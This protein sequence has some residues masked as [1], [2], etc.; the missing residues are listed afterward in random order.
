MKIPT[1][2]L[3]Q[4]VGIDGYRVLAL[5]LDGVCADYTTGL[6][7]AMTNLGFPDAMDLPDPDSYNL[8]RATG[9][10]FQ[11]SK[12]YMAVHREAVRA[13]L[14]RELP[15][16]P[17]ATSAL[18]ELA[19]TDVHIRVL[20][21]RLF[22]GGLHQQIVSDTAYWL[23]LHKIPYMSLCFTG[24][25]DTVDASV[26]IDD[27][28]A[29]IEMLASLDKD[30]VVFDQPYN[31]DLDLPRVDNWEEAVSAILRTLDRDGP[32]RV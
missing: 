9:W 19:S 31:R 18:Q 15:S 25:K 7:Q 4:R 24:L 5:D 30:I 26:Y 20:T 28:P 29:T 10:P 23:D 12:E 27:A 13:G 16:V 22:T 32:D 14:Y 3:N 2:Y 6:K 8:A 17:G 21:H 11:T 1:E